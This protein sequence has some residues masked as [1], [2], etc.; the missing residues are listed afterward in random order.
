MSSVGD[1]LGFDADGTGVCVGV[2]CGEVLR[3]TEG[4]I[5][6]LLALPELDRCVG[7]TDAE[8]MVVLLS[9]AVM[10]IVHTPVFF[11]SEAVSEFSFEMLLDEALVGRVINVRLPVLTTLKVGYV[12]DWE[13]VAVLLGELKGLLV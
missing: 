3:R 13:C 4:V 7:C 9:V 11:D 1:T 12:N 2:G 6:A 10:D 8:P 5:L